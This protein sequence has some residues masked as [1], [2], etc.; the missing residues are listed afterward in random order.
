MTDHLPIMRMEIFPSNLSL[1]VHFIDDSVQILK[2][3]DE[4]PACDRRGC[5]AA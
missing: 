5:M 4:V 1:A 2:P 3:G